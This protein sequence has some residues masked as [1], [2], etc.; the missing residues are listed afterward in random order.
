MD[1]P[2]KRITQK[3]K[4]NFIGTLIKTWYFRNCK[5]DQKFAGCA[6]SSF[7]V[8]NC[9]FHFEIFIIQNNNSVQVV[10]DT[11]FRVEIGVL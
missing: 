5:N 9:A 1:N 3:I 11:P 2:G 6:S 10:M 4:P 8:S 7:T